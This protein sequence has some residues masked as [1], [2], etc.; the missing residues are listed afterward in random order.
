MTPCWVTPALG[1]HSGNDFLS[2]SSFKLDFYATK[3]SI[4]FTNILKEFSLARFWKM[5]SHYYCH[6]F[7]NW[8]VFFCVITDAITQFV[9]QRALQRHHPYMRYCS[10]H[11]SLNK[12]KVDC[13]SVIFQ[14]IIAF[15]SVQGVKVSDTAAAWLPGLAFCP[16]KSL[17]SGCHF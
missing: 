5:F 8:S 16:I 9:Q 1:W 11:S 2:F 10:H 12:N 7:K 6:R 14:A 4:S 17:W 13:F 15:V 3:E